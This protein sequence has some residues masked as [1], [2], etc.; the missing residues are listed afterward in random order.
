MKPRAFTLIE[1]LVVI[2][3]IAI[4]MAILMPSLKLAKDQA[5]RIHCVSNAKALTLGWLLYKDDWDGKL[6]P[7]HTGR[8]TDT[9]VG[10]VNQL[11]WVDEP[12]ALDSNWV[13]KKEAIARGSLFNYVGKEVQIYR[14]PAD[15]RRES[16][17][18]PVAYRTFS[19]AGGA[20]GESWSAYRRCTI[21]S[22]IKRP[23]T[24][25][26]LVEEMDT[27]GLNMGSWQMDPDPINP[28]WTDP[29]AM[30]HN[31]KSTLSYADGS[32][33][34]H[35]WE[36]QSF[37]EWNL[38]FMNEPGYQGFGMN[39]PADDRADVNFMANGFPYKAIR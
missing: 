1:L 17:S 37:I 19:V 7:G 11:Q 38:R 24:T 12:P 26:V 8:R 29:L 10:W 6:V 4:L 2:A 20:N 30:W 9:E 28:S 27:R 36:S 21:Y 3:I 31:K 14:C 16:S 5:T 13:L 23:A 33:E 34:M 15:R 18:L 22:E 35:T 39:P 25:Y 32:A